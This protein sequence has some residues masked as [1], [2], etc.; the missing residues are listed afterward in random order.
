MVKMTIYIVQ[1]ITEHSRNWAN[2]P[3]STQNKGK[4]CKRMAQ[5]PPI[6]DSKLGQPPTL[7]YYTDWYIIQ[8]RILTHQSVHYRT[9]KV[10]TLYQLF[11]M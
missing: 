6:Y 3:L 7:C 9:R 10:C 1:Y 2:F 4:K 8:V 11:C 5:I